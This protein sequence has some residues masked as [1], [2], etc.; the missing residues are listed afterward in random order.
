MKI[1]YTPWIV[2]TKQP[3]KE[4]IWYEFKYELV[5]T[6]C[7]KRLTEKD[8]CRC[9]KK[10]MIIWER[11]ITGHWDIHTCAKCGLIYEFDSAEWEDNPMFLAIRE[12]WVMNK[13]K[14]LSPDLKTLR[15]SPSQI[16]KPHI[17]TWEVK[18]RS[19]SDAGSPADVDVRCISCKKSLPPCN[20]ANP[21]PLLSIMDGSYTWNLEICPQC[22][23]LRKIEKRH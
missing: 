17:H 7:A 14:W 18:K 15:R 4:D 11:D 22:C 19:S 6:K 1:S 20:C 13:K 10:R 3:V 9:R 21:P 16:P 2:P 23:G 12:H 8:L 5:C